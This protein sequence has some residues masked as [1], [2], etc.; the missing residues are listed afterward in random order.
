MPM[1]V[2]ANGTIELTGHCPVEEAETLLQHLLAM[3]GALV[4][5]RGCESAHAALIQVLF[6]AG[7]APLGPPLSD[8]LRDHIE[9]LLLRA[10]SA[11]TTESGGFDT[12]SPAQISPA[13]S[14]KRG[15]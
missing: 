12:M 7:C 13:A 5:W 15:P 3:P 11:R 2:A 10:A 6:V 4:D 14:T 8:F 9:P 1:T